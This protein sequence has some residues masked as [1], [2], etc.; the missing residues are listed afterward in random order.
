MLENQSTV[1][2]EPTC[3]AEHEDA[4]AAMG[5]YKKPDK[6]NW[7]KNNSQFIKSITSQSDFDKQF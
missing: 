7:K 6:R 1:K 5:Y 2:L 4:L 3:L